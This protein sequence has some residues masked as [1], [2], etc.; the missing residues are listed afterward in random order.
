MFLLVSVRHVDAHSDGHQRCVSIQISFNFVKTFLRIS[1]IR[2]IPLTE[3]LARVF[4][5]LPP[6]IS[7]ISDF[8]YWQ[9]RCFFFYL[10]WMAW[11]WKPAILFNGS[12]NFRRTPFSLLKSYDVTSQMNSIYHGTFKWFY[13][14]RSTLGERNLNSTREN[15]GYQQLAERLVFGSNT[16]LTRRRF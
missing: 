2:N 7:Q 13:L 15:P 6:S 10:F 3:I 12:S 11:H 14:L 8:I 4:V 9:F 5:H 1:R 16:S